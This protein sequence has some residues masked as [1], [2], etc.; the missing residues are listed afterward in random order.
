VRLVRAFN[1][2]PHFS[3]RS[4]AHRAGERVGV[5][6]AADDPGALKVATRLVED[7]GFE[8]VVVGPLSRAKEFDVGAGVYGRALS[9]RE[10]R[11]GLKL[12]P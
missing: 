9:A 5:P 12:K 3:L 8:P 4:E 10:L 1:S 7:A 2:L 6:L 11:Q